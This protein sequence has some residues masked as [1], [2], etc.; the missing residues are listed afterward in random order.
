MPSPV[1]K[2]SSA[3]KA[4]SV[5]RNA[6]NVVKPT[7]MNDTTPQS[8]ESSPKDARRLSLPV[9]GNSHADRLRQQFQQ[10]CPLAIEP[11]VCHGQ[12]PNWPR[13]ATLAAIQSSANEPAS[14]RLNRVNHQEPYD[15]WDGKDMLAQCQPDATK[16]RLTLTDALSKMDQPVEPNDPLN[17]WD[18]L[19][20]FSHPRAFDHRPGMFW[21]RQNPPPLPFP[22]QVRRGSHVAWPGRRWGHPFPW[23]MRAAMDDVV[24]EN[25]VPVG[26]KM[27]PPPT[28]TKG[29]L[30]QAIRQEKHAKW[31]AKKLL[32]PKAAASASTSTT[33]VSVR[34]P[35]AG[36]GAG[37]AASA[38]LALQAA[39]ADAVLARPAS[40]EPRVMSR[41]DA[42]AVE[43]LGPRRAGD[44]TGADGAAA[45]YDG[46]RESESSLPDATLLDAINI[47]D[48]PSTFST[49]PAIDNMP[50][51][52]SFGDGVYG[53]PD[54][55]YEGGTSDSAHES[56]DGV[57]DLST[58]TASAVTPAFNPNNDR[59]FTIGFQAGMSSTR[60]S[61]S[62][63]VPST[64]KNFLQSAI[65]F[66]PGMS[67]SS[68]STTS[69]TA[70]DVLSAPNNNLQSAIAFRP[71]M[72]TSSTSSDGTANSL[73]S[74]TADA[75]PSTGDS[76]HVIQT[77][78]STPGSVYTNPQHDSL[79]IHLAATPL[80]PGLRRG[81]RLVKDWLKGTPKADGPNNGR[82]FKK[83]ILGNLANNKG[84]KNVKVDTFPNLP[85]Y[86][87]N[88]RKR[89]GHDG[90]DY[91]DDCKPSQSKKMR[92]G[93]DGMNEARFAFER[94]L[95]R[96]A[97]RKAMVLCYMANYHR[98]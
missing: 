81:F 66:L 39:S 25:A 46:S 74:S 11:Q 63:D 16:Q 92:T 23:D 82:G 47:A 20:E 96:K 31:M 89:A 13:G 57:P 67:T 84:R 17:D 85:V 73:I 58:M 48:L 34:G 65:A 41:D 49:S 88:K 30:G 21:I 61:I 51:T 36:A 53:L 71:G 19:D 12:H 69:V 8:G 24:Q 93:K 37:A 3:S 1:N 77:P 79:A 98:D 18:T 26:K 35:G 54:S 62:S 43:Q 91:E 87:G 44:G 97:A 33:A 70:A 5:D 78:P 42:L 32:E 9:E 56:E 90:D 68:A 6:T 80:L 38:E 15:E 50:T 2:T 22:P 4:Q 40:A 83:W 52:K 29:S 27:A 10:S 75:N 76:S 28:D 86:A 95:I 45:S 59:Q 14:T 55:F 72:S 7:E 60:M 64:P 94:L